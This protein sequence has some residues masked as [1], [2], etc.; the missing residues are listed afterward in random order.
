I[1]HRWINNDFCTMR[2]KAIYQR[3]WLDAL[4]LFGVVVFPYHLI[5]AYTGVAIFVASFMPAAAQVCY[6]GN[7]MQYFGEVMG[8]YHREE[9]H[10]PAAAPRSLDAL[11]AESRRLWDGA[12]VGWVS[13]H[14][15]D[16]AS[17]VVDVRRRDGS[18]IG[19]PQDTLTYDAT[20]GELL[21]RQNASTGYRAYLWL[22][23]LHMAQFGG[24]LVRLLYLLMGLCGCAMLVGGL[25]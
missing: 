4:Y 13:V 3:A 1:I 17:A 11:I 22:A 9:L 8:S 2:P 25:Q 15:P 14:H 16:D 24:G 19:T 20:T 10:Q 5:L 6:S 18:R 23:G 21:N 12:E 7:V